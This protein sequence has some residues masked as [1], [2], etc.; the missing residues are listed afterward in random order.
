[1]AK[2]LEKMNYLLLILYYLLIFSILRSDNNARVLALNTE[3]LKKF[4]GKWGRDRSVLT[5]GSIYL[6]CCVRDTA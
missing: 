3:C 5:L 4:V 6:P 1:M 2:V